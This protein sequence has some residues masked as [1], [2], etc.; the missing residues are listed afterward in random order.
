MVVST[1]VLSWELD[2]IAVVDGNEVNGNLVV[3]SEICRVD[4][5]GVGTGV[6]K[7]V[8]EKVVGELMK[9]TRDVVTTEVLEAVVVV[10]VVVVV[11]VDVVG[12]TG[13]EVLE[14]VVGV[15]VGV[16]VVVV[17][18]DAT[19]VDVLVNIVVEVPGTVD[20]MGLGRID[21]VGEKAEVEEKVDPTDEEELPTNWLLVCIVFELVV[22]VDIVVANGQ[23]S[24]DVR[25]LPSKSVH[26]PQV[27][28]QNERIKSPAF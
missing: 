20:R 5:L 11:E 9:V 23:A 7:G 14:V 19:G 24:G 21:E 27:R 26:R 2:F 18:V 1:L 22:M 15:V 17:E 16:V 3:K 28:K 12:V 4:G 25:L 13:A 6:N 10:V 8:A